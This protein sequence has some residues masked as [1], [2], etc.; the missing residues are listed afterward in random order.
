MSIDVRP[1]DDRDRWNDLLADATHPTAF[2]HAAALDVFE[3]YSDTVCHRLVGFKGEEAIGLFP[4]FTMEKGPFTVA[5][6][7]PPDLK[8]S[9]LGPRMIYRH[10][11][12]R[13]RRDK[14]NRQFVESALDWLEETHDPRFTSI[15]TASQYDDTRPFIWREFEATPRYT[16]VID[17]EREPDELLSAFSSDARSNV[18]SDYDV[19]YEIGPA[20]P[21]AIAKI[22]EQVKQRHAEQEK[23]F[24]L[25][26]EPV[27]ELYRSLPEGVLRPYVCRIDGEFAG[28]V[29]NVEYAGRAIRWLGGTKVDVDIP[30]NDL[31]D[32]NYSRDAMERGAVSYD[33]AGANNPQIASFK[34]KFAP[35]LLTYYSLQRGSAGMTALSRLY[36]K[37]R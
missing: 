32:W 19:D 26:V 3:A 4:L 28:G 23:A 27:E 13:R 22:M 31:L 34:A 18:T 5:F 33:L 2:H 9:Y 15:R 21:D 35:D 25:D 36:G 37:L 29:L 30:I 8:I 10:D 14:R 24:P 17:L 12:K 16:Y 20:G 6:S 1:I 11:P 7:P